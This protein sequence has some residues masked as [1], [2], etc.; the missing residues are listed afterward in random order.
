MMA[1]REFDENS[2]IENTVAGKDT[3]ESQFFG[4]NREAYS[5]E[6]TE[7]LSRLSVLQ[8][9]VLHFISIGFTT[10]EII[11]ELHITKKQYDD[12]YNAIHSYRNI[13]VLL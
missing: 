1:K 13:E 6:M 8:K 5:K 2:T 7:Y 10:N 4:E 11:G 9:E 3:I 12:C